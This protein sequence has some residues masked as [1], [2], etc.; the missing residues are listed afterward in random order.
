M[1]IEVSSF[2]LV[3]TLSMSLV[4]SVATVDLVKSVPWIENITFYIYGWLPLFKKGKIRHAT[5]QA[6][7]ILKSFHQ[8]KNIV[9]ISD[10][11]TQ[12]AS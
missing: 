5:A 4:A 8:G 10:N 2:V 7:R 3:R 9:Y 6:S 1:T 12:D 11:D